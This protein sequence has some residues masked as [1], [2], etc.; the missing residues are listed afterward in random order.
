MLKDKI[1]KAQIK[2]KE[3]KQDLQAVRRLLHVKHAKRDQDGAIRVA[4]I[5]PSTFAW[6]KIASVYQE[7]KNDPRF[8]TTLICL[9]R[10]IKHVTGTNIKGNDTYDWFISHGYPEAINAL[11]GRNRWY[12]LKKLHPDFA[13]FVKPYNG[14][15]PEPYKSFEV[16]K[17]TKICMLSYGLNMTVDMVSSFM[18]KDFFRDVSLFFAECTFVAKV[19]KQK[20][21]LMRMTGLQKTYLYGYPAFEHVFAQKKADCP[22]WEFSKNPFRVM[23]TPRWATDVKLGGNNFFTYYQLFLTYAQNHKDVDWLFRP[24]PLAFD[25]FIKIKKLTQEEVD[26]YIQTCEEMPNVSLD[27]E[28]DYAAT[29]WHTDVLVSDFS[30]LVVEFFI[31]EKPI[32]YCASN[33]HLEL[34]ELAQKLFYEGCYVAYTP[35][36][37]FSV[38]EQL[39]QGH[40]PMKEKRKA[41]IKELFG[42]SLKGRVGKRIAERL[43]LEMHQKQ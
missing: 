33:M 21:W 14:N 3:F 30:T 37:L 23:W 36:D 39:K 16:S 8:H 17:Y 24:H 9:P 4:F 2:L 38:L 1:S 13:F 22:S 41:L 31:T 11:E 7:L 40:D 26:R 28:K 10:I 20:L 15:V 25:H 35:D 5:C 43:V 27:K 32:I 19:N 34:S 12:D 29:F 6:G 42:K 18:N